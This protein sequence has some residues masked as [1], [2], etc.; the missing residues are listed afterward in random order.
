LSL[1]GY[2]S[3]S[4]RL[5]RCQNSAL[6]FLSTTS[7]GSRSGLL[8]PRALRARTGSLLQDS[9]LLSAHL[10]YPEAPSGTGPS[11]CGTQPETH[12]RVLDHRNSAPSLA[13]RGKRGSFVR[14]HAHVGARNSVGD[15]CSATNGRELQLLAAAISEESC[16]ATMARRQV[17]HSSPTK[18]GW[19]VT[20]SREILSTHSTQKEAEA[21]AIKAGR[22]AQAA[23]STAQAVL[24]KSD[25]TIREERTFGN[26][27]RRSKG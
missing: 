15:H 27:P 14:V 1:V 8:S 5:L 18:D 24:H 10:R 9:L 26:D 11:V 21:A 7:G 6:L 16:E 17:F 12:P 25:G 13:H 2:P 20:Q 4:K 22:A 23:G 3:S 19:K